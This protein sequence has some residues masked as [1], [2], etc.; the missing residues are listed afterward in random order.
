MVALHSHAFISLSIL[1]FCLVSLVEL[2]WPVTTPVL[3]WVNVAIG[4]WIPLYLLI[5]QKRVYRQ[6]WFM[7]VL[8]WGLIG[9]SYITLI[10]TAVAI[11]AV[12]GL[13]LQ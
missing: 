13:M 1:L 2:A 3:F 5:M 11:A 7:T 12:V 4:A 6:N 10:S 8:K 9:F